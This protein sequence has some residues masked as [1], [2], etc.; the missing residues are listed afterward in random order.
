M[1]GSRETGR[2]GG[3][4]GRHAW[5]RAER[6]LTVDLQDG[7][8]SPCELLRLLGERGRSPGAFLVTRREAL[9]RR[10]DFNV[11]G[12]EKHKKNDCKKAQTEI[13]QQLDSD[14]VPQQPLF[15]ASNN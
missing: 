14:E 13:C 1:Q 10:P 5:R 3:R 8:D 6:S 4:A 15:I 7:S 11:S 9:R 12:A 2:G